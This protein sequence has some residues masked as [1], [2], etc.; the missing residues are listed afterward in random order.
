MQTL[1]T[2]PNFISWVLVYSFAFILFSVDNG[3]LNNLLMN[4]DLIEQ[5]LNILASDNHT[6]LSMTLWGVW[7]GLGWGAI[8]Y[9]AAI[10]FRENQ[11]P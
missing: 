2:L 8:L 4:L 5:P 7:K 6:W 10:T 3:F 1:T 11:I 9:I